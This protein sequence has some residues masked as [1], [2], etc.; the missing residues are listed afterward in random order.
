MFDTVA[1][2]IVGVSVVLPGFIIAD[3]AEARRAQRLARSDWELVLRALIYA[4]VLQ[5]LVLLTGWTTWLI[6][7]AGLLKHAKPGAT[8][9]WENHVDAIA[10]YVVVVILD[11][12]DDHRPRA[13]K[14]SATRGEPRLA[15]LDSL[16]PRRARRTRRVGLH[17]P[18]LRRRLRL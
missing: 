2:I 3:L 1:G 18:A 7:T 12:A 16:R 5:S 4:L 11:R 15:D 17:L 6:D 14:D 8:P 10:L 13:R 9:L